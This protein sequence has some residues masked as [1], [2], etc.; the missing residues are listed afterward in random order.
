MMWYMSIKPKENIETFKEWGR[1]KVLQSFEQHSP[2]DSWTHYFWTYYCQFGMCSFSISIFKTCLFGD[3]F[4]VY[5]PL[6]GY[7]H[8]LSTR[9]LIKLILHCALCFIVMNDWPSMCTTFQPRYINKH[10]V[11]PWCFKTL[12]FTWNK[13]S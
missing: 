13:K 10:W 3:S 9:T 12:V 4:I 11:L 2:S 7:D 1:I 8:V 6:N 5:I